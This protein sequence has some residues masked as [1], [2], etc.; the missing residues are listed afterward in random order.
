MK[1]DFDYVVSTLGAPE[2]GVAL[3]RG[4]MEFFEAHFPQSYVDFLIKYGLGAY[5]S[6]GWW[7][8]DPQEYRSILALIFQADPLFN[9]NSFHIVG[10]SA[11]GK[12]TV[13]SEEHFQVDIDLLKYEVTSQALAPSVFGGPVFDPPDNPRPISAETQIGNIIPYDD[14]ARE[15][16][17]YPTDQK[18]FSRCVRAYGALERGECFGF[19]PSLG[20]TNFNSKYRTVENVKRVSALE[21]FAIIA[22]LKPFSLVRSNM[23][24]QE[25]VRQI[26]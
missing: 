1:E 19:F 21:H 12:L 3:T 7:F 13:W 9:H 2:D 23:G 24:S 8:V 20:A 4:Q 5:F 11:F 16:W 26:G 10:Y 17:D 18:M 6:K 15:C 14:N 22:Q 25:T